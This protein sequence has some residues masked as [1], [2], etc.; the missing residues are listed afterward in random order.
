MIADPPKAVPSGDLLFGKEKAHSFP[1][2][3]DNRRE[4]KCWRERGKAGREKR[5]R[6]GSLRSKATGDPLRTDGKPPGKLTPSPCCALRCGEESLYC[7]K[8]FV[9][10]EN[11]WQDLLLKLW[12]C[13]GRIR[14]VLTDLKRLPLEETLNKPSAAAD[15]PDAPPWA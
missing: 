11:L 4:R 2:T 5:G 9:W 7:T 6:L 3:G 14:H 13:G 8:L 15:E 10:R 12:V 1:A